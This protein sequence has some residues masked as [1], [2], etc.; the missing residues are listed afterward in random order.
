MSDFDRDLEAV[1]E[2]RAREFSPELRELLRQ[3][4]NE[5]VRHGRL[6]ERLEHGRLVKI[7]E[8]S[9]PGETLR[10]RRVTHWLTSGTRDEASDPAEP[11]QTYGSW[12]DD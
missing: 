9:D 8:A 11:R 7:T 3:L 10:R 4:W 12:S 5:G 6:T 2:E 1:F